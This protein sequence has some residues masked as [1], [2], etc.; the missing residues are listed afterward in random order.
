M[1]SYRN[2]IAVNKSILWIPIAFVVVF[3]YLFPISINLLP[4]STDLILHAVGIVYVIFWKKAVINIEHYRLCILS[5]VVVLLSLFHTTINNSFDFSLIVKFIAS[6][7]FI[8]SSILVVDIIK[9]T[10][11]SFSEIV[12]LEWI[13]YVTIGQA[14]ISLI[15]FIQPAL[16]DIWLSIMKLTDVGENIA[17]ASAGFRLIAFAKYQFAN[18]AVMYGL[19][20]LCAITIA[21]SGESKFYNNYKLLYYVSVILVLVA[22]ILSARTFFIILLMAI[23]YASFLLWRKKGFVSILYIASLSVIIILLIASAILFLENSEY[24]RTY[25]WAFEWLINFQDSGKLQ[26][27]STSTLGNMYFFPEQ[28]KTWLIGD[29]IFSN[30]D[31]TFYKETD[32]GY[33]RSLFYWGIIGSLIYYLIQYMYFRVVYGASSNKYVRYFIVILIVWLFIYNIKD[34]W[35]ANMYWPLLLSA[36][37]E[38]NYNKKKNDKRLHCYS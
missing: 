27:D 18:M 38:V 21:F 26:T 7:L 34:M 22:G 19:A 4:V 31:G 23:L 29:G 30:S 13:L 28:T 33:I 35:Q 15:L 36:M 14:I 3:T 17:S 16:M 25:K 2:R 10:T 12:I 8:P 1:I 20:L 9:K 24:A 6:L 11:R 5:L 32:A 37:V